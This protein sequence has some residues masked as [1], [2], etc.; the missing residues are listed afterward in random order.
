MIAAAVAQATSDYSKDVP[1]FKAD[2]PTADDQAAL[3]KALAPAY[4]KAARSLNKYGTTLHAIN[5]S[6]VKL[7][8][9][10]HI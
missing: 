8:S 10:I 5:S 1:S 7:L 6:I 9:L 3:R 2:K 4:E